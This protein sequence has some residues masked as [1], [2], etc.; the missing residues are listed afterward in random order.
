[1][2]CNFTLVFFFSKEYIIFIQRTAAF[3]PGICQICQEGGEA[4]P[5]LPAPAAQDAV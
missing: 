4:F 3:S 2:I 5:K 1:M